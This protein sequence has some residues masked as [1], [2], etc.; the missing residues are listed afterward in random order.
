MNLSPEESAALVAELAL[1]TVNTALADMHATQPAL[2]ATWQPVALPIAQVPMSPTLTMPSE[3]EDVP[4]QAG[5]PDGDFRPIVH[6]VPRVIRLALAPRAL[7]PLPRPRPVTPFLSAP[8]V[9]PPM[10]G[11]SPFCRRPRTRRMGCLCFRCEHLRDHT[12]KKARRPSMLS[13]RLC[14]YCDPRVIHGQQGDVGG[15]VFWPPDMVA[16]P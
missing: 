15:P 12:A 3:A 13:P 6:A 8:D 11:R 4:M 16:P 7:R 9:L 1:P 14:T 10:A 2:A 5:I